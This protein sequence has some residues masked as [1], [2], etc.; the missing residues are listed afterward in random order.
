MKKE[1]HLLL[2]AASLQRLN[3]WPERGRENA[4]IYLTSSAWKKITIWWSVKTPGLPFS[5]LRLNITA[6]RRCGGAAS[7]PTLLS[8]RS[9]RGLV[10]HAPYPQ[11]C[12][13]LAAAHPSVARLHRWL[14][15]K[16]GE[17]FPLA[18]PAHVPAGV[19]KTFS[20]PGRKINIWMIMRR[21]GGWGGGD[22]RGAGSMPG[23][24]PHQSASPAPVF[25]YKSGFIWRS[26][27]TDLFWS[28][29]LRQ[30]YFKATDG[31]GVWATIS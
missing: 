26:P 18:G 30:L 27:R 19:F 11:V 4:S 5:E 25:T 7:C 9:T 17:C 2:G 20:P 21:V 24:P 28:L 15:N 23:K 31:L 8:S 12:P 3:Q 16:E 29:A 10:H 22:R 14:A 6:L 13:S 1:S